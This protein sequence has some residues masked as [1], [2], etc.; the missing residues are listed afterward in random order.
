MQYEPVAGALLRGALGLVRKAGAAGSTACFPGGGAGHLVQVAVAHKADEDAAGVVVP[1]DARD[2]GYFHSGV[3]ACGFG[4]AGLLVLPGLRGLRGL[5]GRGSAG[6]RGG[7]GDKRPL[8][9][10]VRVGLGDRFGAA[11]RLEL[12]SGLGL[13]SGFGLGRARGGGL[14]RVLSTSQRLTLS[15]RQFPS[16]RLLFGRLLRDRGPLAGWRGVR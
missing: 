14:G 4:L 10:S 1:R 15:R 2:H 16:R 13:G 12:G 8:R 9:L 5:P 11:R 7:A 3:R 6:G